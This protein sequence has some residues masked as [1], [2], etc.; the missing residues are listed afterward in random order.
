MKKAV[1]TLGA[2]LTVA[3]ASAYNGSQNGMTGLSIFFLIVSI[4][5]MILSV[6]ILVRWWKMTD[7]VRQLRE[8]LTPAKPRLSYLMAIG[9]KEQAEK[10]ALKMVIDI[11]YPIYTDNF[12]YT[13]AESMN[14]ALKDLLPQIKRLGIVLPDYATS[15]EKFIDYMNKLTGYNVPYH[16]PDDA[17]PLVIMTENDPEESI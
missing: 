7:D 5:Y 9:E 2:V 4:L 1:L 6:V 3:T 15:G 12:H 8:K 10:S 14:T 16:T 13:K 11:L 17:N